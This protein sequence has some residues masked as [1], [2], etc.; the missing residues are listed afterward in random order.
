MKSGFFMND[1]WQSVLSTA[2]LALVLSVVV[3]VLVL[4]SLV[5]VLLPRD[6]MHPRY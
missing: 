2:V 3:L 1:T 6:A 4:P 5:L